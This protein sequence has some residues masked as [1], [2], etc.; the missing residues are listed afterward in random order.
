MHQ[1]V[2]DSISASDTTTL[3]SELSVEPLNR[4][5]QAQRRTS[6]NHQLRA[7]SASIM[8]V[9]AKHEPTPSLC[10]SEVCQ[11]HAS[12]RHNPQRFHASGYRHLASAFTVTHALA[13]RTCAVLKAFALPSQHSGCRSKAGSCRFDLGC[14]PRHGTVDRTPAP[15]NTDRAWIGVGSPG[16]MRHPQHPCQTI[17]TGAASAP[18]VNV[19]APVDDPM[20]P[21]C[22]QVVGIIDGSD[23]HRPLSRFSHEKTPANAARL[24]RPRKRSLRCGDTNLPKETCFPHRSAQVCDRQWPNGEGPSDQHCRGFAPAFRWSPVRFENT[25][26]LNPPSSQHFQ[27]VGKLFEGP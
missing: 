26:R 1:R 11:R 3:P 21:S 12:R 10:R 6:Y 25:V 19:C 22:T 18:V 8:F 24:H 27:L 23:P 5:F 16:T 7:V 4:C 9:T 17:H 13:P 14:P 20:L 15:C 2:S